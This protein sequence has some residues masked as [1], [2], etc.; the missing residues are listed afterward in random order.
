ME[1]PIEVARR[2]CAAWSD[3][4]GAAELGQD[5]RLAGLFRHEPV[6]QPDGIGLEL[7][8]SRVLSVWLRQRV[9]ALTR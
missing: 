3:D 6:H 9:W 7:F 1:S 5:Q 4:T 8:E 2:F